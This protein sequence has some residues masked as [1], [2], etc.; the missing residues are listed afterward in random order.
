VGSFA[1]NGYGLYDMAG[2]IFEWCWDRWAGTYY[3]TSP[4]SD[5]RGPA[6]GTGRSVRGGGWHGGANG[7]RAASRAFGDP[8]GAVASVGFRLARSSV[9]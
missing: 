1:S 4:G 7:C 9:P 8:T 5:P 3:T 2:N 6:L